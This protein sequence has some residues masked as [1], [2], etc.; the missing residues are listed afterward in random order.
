MSSPILT[1][2][3]IK[4]GRLSNTQSLYFCGALSNR[5]LDLGIWG[6][7][8][9]FNFFN[10]LLSFGIFNNISMFPHSGKK[11]LPVT[12]YVILENKT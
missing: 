12:S 11:K 10:F 7:G 4:N 5:Y 3:Y 1:M 6:G 8:S 9:F 2:I